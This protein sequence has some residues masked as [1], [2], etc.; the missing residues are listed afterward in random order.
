MSDET[1]RRTHEP[2][3]L[4]TQRLLLRPFRLGDV[5]DVFEYADDP[6]LARYFPTIPIPYVRRDAEEFLA[7]A[8][9]A[10]WETQPIFAIE[11]DSKVIGGVS[12]KIDV[13]NETGELG[14]AIGRSHWGQGLVPEAG[15]AVVDWVF[16]EFGLAKVHAR[17]DLRNVGSQRVMEKVG[18]TREGVLRSHEKRRGVR[19]DYVYYGL[20]REEWEERQEFEGPH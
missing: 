10:P 2:V 20:L 9:L 1:A 4:T 8:V 7:E 18:M 5:E 3:E 13:Q 19:V 12:V 17:A 14:Y 11:L 6:E 15:T 16:Q